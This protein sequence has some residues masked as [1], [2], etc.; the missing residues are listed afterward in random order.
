MLMT[1]ASQ[2]VVKE[3]LSTDIGTD[4]NSKPVTNIL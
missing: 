2:A 1:A 4:M 3:L